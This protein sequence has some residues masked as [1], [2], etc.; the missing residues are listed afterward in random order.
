MLCRYFQGCFSQ[1]DAGG[2]RPL[3]GQRFS[4][5]ATTT[6]DIKHFLAVQW[7]IFLDEIGSQWVDDVQHTHRSFR[8]PPDL[9]EAIKFFDFLRVY[10]GKFAHCSG[11][12]LRFCLHY[13]L[14]EG[15]RDGFRDSCLAA[16]R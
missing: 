8:I 1:V 9:C 6:A 11:F 5:D 7:R 13:G 4:Q 14:H 12:N 10:I 2:F 15:L 3:P 16:I